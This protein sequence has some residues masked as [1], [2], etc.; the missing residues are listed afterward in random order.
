MRVRARV[1]ACVRLRRLGESVPSSHGQDLRTCWGPHPP[2]WGC[3]L[4]PGRA[5][6]CPPLL[7]SGFG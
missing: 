6:A 2:P 1:R 7:G 4:P 5:R 3:G